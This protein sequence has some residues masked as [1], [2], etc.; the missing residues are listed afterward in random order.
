[1]FC[2][3]LEYIFNVEIGICSKNYMKIVLPEHFLVCLSPPLEKNLS[4]VREVDNPIPGNGVV[5]VH[6]LLL[7]GVKA[8]HLHGGMKVKVQ[9]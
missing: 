7:H 9:Y 1:M 6:N 5:Q 8:K 2:H 3:Q 4:E